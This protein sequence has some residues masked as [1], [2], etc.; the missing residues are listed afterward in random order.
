MVTYDNTLK[1]IFDKKGI[2]Y[3]EPYTG[4][5]YKDIETVQQYSEND[6]SALTQAG[7]ISG[8][9]KESDYPDGLLRPTRNIS[10]I[11]LARMLK[12]IG[13]NYSYGEQETNTPVTSEELDKVLSE[14]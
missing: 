5:Y 13:Y 14:L 6:L 4:D 1:A 10:H 11:D 2:K 7:I 8:I 9:I 12:G 3:N